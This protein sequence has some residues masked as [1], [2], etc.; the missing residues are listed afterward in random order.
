MSQKQV[1][2]HFIYK[3]TDTRNGNFYVGMHSTRNARQFN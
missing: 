3:T 2:Y 1:K